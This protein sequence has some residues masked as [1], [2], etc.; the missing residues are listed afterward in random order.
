MGGKQTKA[1][2]EA[3]DEESSA[4]EDD[5]VKSTDFTSHTHTKNKYK[6]LK[7]LTKFGQFKDMYGERL[8]RDKI[9]SP[10]TLFSEIFQKLPEEYTDQI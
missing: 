1:K 7:L 9:L 8:E 10:R 6:A 3:G 5:F 4:E 2:Y